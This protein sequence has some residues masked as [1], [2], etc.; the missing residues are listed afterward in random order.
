MIF[1]RHIGEAIVIGTGE[2]TVT[3]KVL[4]IGDRTVKVG[5]SAPADIRIDRD[6][7]RREI[8]EW[9]TLRGGES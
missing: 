5:I 8:E 1:K 9:E 4:G 7:V 6:E 3:I 2:K